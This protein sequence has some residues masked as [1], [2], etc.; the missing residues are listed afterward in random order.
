MAPFSLGR[1]AL[2][3]LPCVA[4]VMV[5]CATCFSYRLRGRLS[6]LPTEL[7]RHGCRLAVV[8][9]SQIVDSPIWQTQ[10]ACVTAGIR[11]AGM[12]QPSQPQE[13]CATHVQALTLDH[14]G[15]HERQLV[16]IDFRDAPL[17]RGARLLQH[18]KDCS[19]SQEVL[20]SSL[21]SPTRCAIW[22]PKI[23]LVAEESIATLCACKHGFHLISYICCANASK[24]QARAPAR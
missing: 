3:P 2:V 15:F 13:H 14:H 17:S 22:R 4:A 7:H 21:R 9:W 11:S 6:A 1:H 12:K 23:S 5:P 24:P 16:S 10:P 19:P 8:D 18:I 20:A